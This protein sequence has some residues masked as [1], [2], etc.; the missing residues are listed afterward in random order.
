MT[1]HTRR[2]LT[3]LALFTVLLAVLLAAALPG[4]D[5]RRSKMRASRRA[6][7]APAPSARRGPALVNHTATIT[8]DPPKVALSQAPSASS[9]RAAGYDLEPEP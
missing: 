2:A 1:V 6:E 8:G 3:P 5:A 9:L 7:D 4:V